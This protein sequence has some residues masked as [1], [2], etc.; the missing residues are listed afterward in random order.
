MGAVAA[1][2]GPDER[3]DRARVPSAS[4]F[5]FD[6]VGQVAGGACSNPA[7]WS[8]AWAG[9]RTEMRRVGAAKG[10]NGEGGIR[11]RGTRR[12]TAFPMPPDQ[13]L[14]HLSGRRTGALYQFECGWQAL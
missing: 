2:N 7:L 6:Y 14:R 12:Y 1:D 10:I 9:M 13:P 4:D 5:V 11:I 3:R 8:V